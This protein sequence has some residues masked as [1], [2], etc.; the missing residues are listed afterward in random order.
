[1]EY[2]RTSN[3][4]PKKVSFLVAKIKFA[5]LMVHP[6]VNQHVSVHIKTIVMYTLT[7]VYF[8]QIKI[9]KNIYRHQS[10]NQIKTL[11][12]E[13]CKN[14][15]H[16]DIANIVMIFDLIFSGSLVTVKYLRL[17]R[18]HERFPDAAHMTSWPLQPSNNKRLS[19]SQPFHSS[20]I[21]T[22]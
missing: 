17:E 15:V 7:N 5:Y 13:I 4:Y 20:F 2:V 9:I 1:M 10:D 22:S 12:E 11:L 19:L 6:T 14:K 8:S 16:T 3:R 18:Y 21:E